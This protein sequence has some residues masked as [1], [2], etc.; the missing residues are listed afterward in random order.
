MLDSEGRLGKGLGRAICARYLHGGLLHTTCIFTF[1]RH[2]EFS[3]C[4]ELQESLFKSF[5]SKPDHQSI[6]FFL[7]HDLAFP[8]DPNSV[9]LPGLLNIVSCDHCGHARTPKKRQVVP[10]PAPDYWVHTYSG[11]IQNQYLW[12]MEKCHRQRKSSPLPPTHISNLPLLLWQ[13][14]HVQQLF[15][16]VLH[17]L[18]GH[19]VQGS[20][21]LKCFPNCKLLIETN[22]L[23]HV[24]YRA[25]P[26]KCWAIVN[27]DGPRVHL[28][29]SQY[30]GKQGG[31]PT[32]TGA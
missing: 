28:L 1:S 20:K 19:A 10:Y 21:I 30:A 4:A 23:W 13:V 25:R 22:I 16:P 32:P 9:R 2:I 26:V 29:P 27:Q 15:L 31:L 11:L 6:R 7:H 24:A 18:P 12:L 8:H 14:Q 17:L 3:L 5:Y